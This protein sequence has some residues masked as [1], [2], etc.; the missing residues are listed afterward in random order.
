MQVAD[1]HVQ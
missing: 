1:N